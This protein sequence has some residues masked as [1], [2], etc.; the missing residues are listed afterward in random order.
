MLNP[1]T[2]LEGQLEPLMLSQVLNEPK[3]AFW[4][5]AAMVRVVEMVRFGV[6]DVTFKLSPFRLF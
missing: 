4:G 3:V 5:G 2:L 6:K 1:S